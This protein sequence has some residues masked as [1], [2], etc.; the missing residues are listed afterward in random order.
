MLWLRR[1]DR[2]CD[3]LPPTLRGQVAA[4]P[5]RPIVRRPPAAAQGSIGGCATPTDHATAFR[6]PCE[7][8][9]RLRLTGRPSDGLPPALRGRAAAEP[10]RPTERRLP[11]GATVPGGGCAGPTERVTASHHPYVAGCTLV[12]TDRQRGRVSTAPDRPCDD[13]LMVVTRQND[14][15]FNLQSEFLKTAP[16]FNFP[17]KI[18]I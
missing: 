15:Q 14:P 3:G 2:P 9:W 11:S 18:Q 17:V 10:Y 8:G 6:R 5:D 16:C 4:A 1:T 12:R 7:A 13:T